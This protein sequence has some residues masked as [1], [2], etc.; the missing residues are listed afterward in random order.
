MRMLSELIQ[1]S[2][3]HDVCVISFTPRNAFSRDPSPALWIDSTINASSAS[4]VNSGG[5]SN[6]RF[7]VCHK[8]LI[9]C[10]ALSK[11]EQKEPRELSRTNR[12]GN[13]AENWRS[14][15]LRNILKDV[16]GAVSSFGEPL[17]TVFL[18]CAVLSSLI[19]LSHD[20]SSV[21]GGALHLASHFL[22]TVRCHAATSNV[23]HLLTVA[24]LAGY[25][26]W[27]TQSQ[28]FEQIVCP[29]SKRY[30]QSE[31]ELSIFKLHKRTSTSAN[32]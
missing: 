15:W 31:A 7:H 2:T 14:S 8:F 9:C 3:H 22:S 4:N 26:W 21:F 10:N 18:S 32:L 25:L 29:C 23:K 17:C 24:D 1:L 28:F 13:A 11:R 19:Q 20:C 12:R 16:F 5:C 27:K 6:R 30:H